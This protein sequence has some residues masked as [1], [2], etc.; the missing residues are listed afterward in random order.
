M[1]SQSVASSREVHGCTHMRT[2]VHGTMAA[3]V[4]CKCRCPECKLARRRYVKRWQSGARRMTDS[5]KARNRVLNMRMTMTMAEVAEATGLPKDY[6]RRVMHETGDMLPRT[7]KAIMSTPVPYH[8][9]KIEGAKWM[10]PAIGAERRLQGLSLLGWTVEMIA[11]ETGL[12]VNTLYPIRRGERDKINAR[13]DALIRDAAE[14]LQLKKLQHGS[15]YVQAG[16]DRYVDPGWAPLMA[17]DDD[18]I[19]DPDARPEGRRRRR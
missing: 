19:D 6:I 9:V 12:S 11:N 15:K 1:E 16:I 7:V 8:P 17:W 14:R 4:N 18:T 3:Y 13:I 5:R 2:H 10:V